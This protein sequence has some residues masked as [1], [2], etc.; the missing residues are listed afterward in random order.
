M[1]ETAAA[2][3]APKAAK[4]KKVAKPKKAATHPTYKVMAAAAIVALKDRKGSSRQAILKYIMANNNL[5]TSDAKQVNSRLKVALK[6]GL[7]DGALKNAKGTG[8]TGSF[9]VAEKPKA[10]KA[11][12][13][14]K[15]KAD[16][17]KK[18]Q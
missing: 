3:P 7:K 9:K 1:T 4:A 17:P 18:S 8:V 2:A 10:P 6:N 14:K 11:K 13:A 5:G 12:K 16:K 15:P